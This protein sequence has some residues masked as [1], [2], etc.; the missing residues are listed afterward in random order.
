MQDLRLEPLPSGD[1]EHNF[2]FQWMC[3]V[4]CEQF[5]S[6]A[7]T[8]FL[9]LFCQLTSDAQLPVRHDG[10]ASLKCFKQT[11]GRFKKKCRFFAFACCS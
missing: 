2:T 3:L 4:V 7:P 9:K 5:G 8:K 6:S 11:V 10:T 1:Y